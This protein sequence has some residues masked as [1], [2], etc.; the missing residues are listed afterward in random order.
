MPLSN[1][2]HMLAIPGPSV[3]PDRVLRAMHRGSPNI[4]EGELH[5]VTAS[6]LADLRKVAGT[7]GH[8]APYICNGHGTWEAA[9]SNVL[10]A[11]DK[12]VLLNTG[13][14]AEGWAAVATSLGA[15]VV[16]VTRGDNLPADPEQLRKAL[17]GEDIKAVLMCHVDTS[18]GIRSDVRAMADVIAELG[19][20][21]LLMVDCIASLG[22]D[23]YEM[24][25]M[26]ADVTIAASQKGLMVP[27]GVGFVWF[28][29]RA[30]AV[31]DKLDRV[32]P[33]WDWAPR[34]EA[35][36][37]YW[38][39]WAGTAPTHHVYG[40]REALDMIFEE[41]LE[42]IWAR[43]EVLAQAH[44]AAVEGWGLPMALNVADPAAR[45]CAITS[46]HLPD[47]QAGALQD[48][49]KRCGVTLG[50]GLGRDPMEDWFRFGHMG[51]VNGHMIMG[52]LGVVEAGLKALGVPHGPGLSAAAEVLS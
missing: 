14:F 30:A 46:V 12:V 17:Q 29:D 35:T 52:T 6:V 36:Q 13:R 42:A 47:G 8:L 49:V 5:D 7:S 10:D 34:V 1:G 50:I 44:W 48:W 45:S 41:G 22:C 20:E 16:A 32:S 15:E 25:A 4:Y 28:N 19:S 33:Y 31:R 40:L 23:R 51:H 9:L 27:A 37:G 39:H 38:Q 26:G 24:D 21:A 18:T 3:M 2:P 43:H 11:G